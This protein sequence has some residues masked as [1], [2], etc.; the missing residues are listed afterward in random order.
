MKKDKNIYYLLVIIL[1]LYS[2]TKKII[3]NNPIWLANI[4]LSH[5]WLWVVGRYLTNR[6]DGLSCY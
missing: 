3:V 4:Q 1:T 2:N 6:E 5:Y